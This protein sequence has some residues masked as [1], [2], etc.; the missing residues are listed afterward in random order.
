MSFPPLAEYIF[1][2]SFNMPR[3]QNPSKI[4]SAQLSSLEIRS[5]KHSSTPSW[6]SQRAQGI[7][8]GF[9]KQKTRAGI[10]KGVCWISPV[11]PLSCTAQPR[12]GADWDCVIPAQPLAPQAGP[13]SPSSSAHT[14]CEPQKLRSLPLSLLNLPREATKASETLKTGR[15]KHQSC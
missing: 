6:V 12:D 13:G 5:Q 4:P 2:L 15:K 3:A 10:A 14:K 1:I 11:K 8:H 9:L 7:Y